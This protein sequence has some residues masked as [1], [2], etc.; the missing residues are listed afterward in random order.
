MGH[1]KNIGSEIVG[2]LLSGLFGS[3]GTILVGGTLADIWTT[4]DR[5]VPMSCFTIA[6]PTYCGYIDMY[7]G[8][9]WIEWVHM[10][11]NGVL[12]IAE[13]FLLKETRGAKI[14]ATRA[15]KL[16]KETGNPNIRA[17][18]ELESE[19][20]KKLLK[21]SCTRAVMLMVHEP[22]LLAFGFWIAM[23]WG[24]TFLFL[25]VI[26]L[27]FAGNHGWSEG[28]AGLPYI[29]LMIGCFIG[30]GTGFW[31]DA[32]YNKVRDANGGVPIPEYRLWGAMHFA[33]A[34]PVGLF[35]FSFTQFAFVHWIAPCIAL[36]LIILG[37]YHIFLATYNYTSDA[38]G[39]MS[40]SAIAGQGAMRNGF[41]ASFPLFATQMFKGMGYQ[42]A[43]LLLSLI[44]L[45]LAPIPFVLFKWG[46]QIRSKSRFAVT[47]IE[48]DDSDEKQ[49]DRPPIA[50][51][52]V[53][54]AG[55]V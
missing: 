41:A 34:L 21:K 16:R 12:F 17:P 53:H 28:N 40:S 14:L 50:K 38:Y 26:P 19:S 7:I 11:E 48:S 1:S 20:V 47:E 54:T 27:T 3:C 22:V 43:G 25:S 10:I 39:E 37:V 8:W 45:A 4:R 33:I 36:V 30:F 35:I 32:K 6:A 49:R 23:A 9:R 15:K 51:E 13:V 44:T 42:Y 5:G 24:I 55:L 18:A 29:A 31:S 52:S 2:R 46:A